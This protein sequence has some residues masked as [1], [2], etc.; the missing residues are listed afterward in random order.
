MNRDQ[1]YHLP[2]RLFSQNLSHNIGHQCVNK[3]H[4]RRVEMSHSFK[5]VLQSKCKLLFNLVKSVA[6]ILVTP[7]VRM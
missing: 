4:S 2:T 6:A 1:G 7:G 3:V 5:F